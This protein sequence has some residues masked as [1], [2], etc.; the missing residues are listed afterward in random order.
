MALAQSAWAS[1]RYDR[2]FLKEMPEMLRGREPGDVT[3][4]LRAA[5][6]EAG[7]VDDVI[8]EWPTELHAV[9][10]A[11]SWAQP[12]DL[13]VLPTH[14]QKDAVDALLEALAVQGW[15]AGEPLAIS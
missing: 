6:Q 7:V 1:A 14:A 13:L 9:R 10:A 15:Q 3:R 8:S 11:L 4:V 5:L 12:G 2:V